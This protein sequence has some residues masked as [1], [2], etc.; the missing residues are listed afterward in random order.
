MQIMN[1]SSAN[2]KNCYKCVRTCV[3]KAIEVKDDQ[4]QI[5]EDRCVACGQCL[6][7]CPQNARNIL[8][9]V[10]DVKEKIDQGANVV[11][12]LAPA[13]RGFFKED[14]KFIG[15]LKKLGFSSIQETSIG[16]ELVSRE[17]EKL[18]N[19]REDRELITSC[20]PSVIMM[21][22][23]YYPELIPSVLPVV[24]P[25][26][27]HGKVIKS[28]EPDSYVVF[29]GPCFSKT[30]ESMAAG[31]EGIIDSVITFDEISQWFDNDGID[32]TKCQESE[33]DESGTLRGH[34][35][36]LVGGIISS[37]RDTLDE[38]DMG[39]LRVHTVEN[40]KTVL[41][42]IRDGGLHNVCVEL[43]ACNESCLGGPGG[44]SNE[45]TP[46]ARLQ[47]LQKHVYNMKKLEEKE[48]QEN[49]K[50]PEV[51][52]SRSFT[53]KK[54]QGEMPSPEELEIILKKMGKYDY[55]DELNCSACGYNTCRDKA[56]AVYQGMSQVEMCLPNMRNKAERM[57][58]KIFTHSPNAIIVLDSNLV[59]E[60][61]NS[62][63]EEVFGCQNETIKGKPF[64]IIMDE[65]DFRE[66][67]DKKCSRFK[68]KISYPQYNYIAYRNI[69][70]LEKQN[71]LLLIFTGITEEE[72]RKK[73]LAGLK[74]ELMEV[75]QEII[76]KQMRTVQEIA[77]LL[78]E[79]TSETKVAFLKL[80]KVLEEEGDV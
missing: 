50:L 33:P 79:S 10:D 43:S 13:Y 63:A 5:I 57:S 77:G 25:M 56:V 45:E 36:P 27:A 44:I 6:V 8:S 49:I 7:V 29:I 42:E 34:R 67:I 2:C 19:E 65:S 64:S 70:Y 16:A 39:V 1:F 58:N 35:Y 75:T 31:M 78:G 68:E 22:E 38:K 28:Q 14:K 20:C 15:A 74:Q 71:A 80:Q 51:D 61:L 62:S 12:T 60:E 41:E 69:V 18:I 55:S 66:A 73:E 37:V 32:Y 4:A 23:R 9:H 40:C 24:S 30:C 72:K 54:F 46:Y 53:N 47:N 48:G 52:L 17:Y 3:V 11:A 76:D 59:I 21:I 26:M